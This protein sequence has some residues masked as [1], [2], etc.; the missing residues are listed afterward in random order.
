MSSCRATNAK[1]P[2]AAEYAELL[3]EAERYDP[4]RWPKTSRLL[5]DL[6]AAIRKLVEREK[7]RRPLLVVNAPPDDDGLRAHLDLDAKPAEP[8]RAD[9][10]TLAELNAGQ[11]DAEMI[12]RLRAAASKAL[13]ELTSERERAE[14]AEADL[15]R[16]REAHALEKAERERNWNERNTAREERDAARA[17]VER[18]KAE[19]NR[20]VTAPCW[21]DT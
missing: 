15:A 16:E 4:K 13:V 18:L 21:R 17:E 9:V 1:E 6:A 20:A 12:R 8:E 11:R 14:Q 10:A 3:R 2:D 5:L 7:E 19:P